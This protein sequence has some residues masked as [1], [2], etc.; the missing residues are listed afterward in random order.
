MFYSSFLLMKLRTALSST[1]LNNLPELRKVSSK[2]SWHCCS[3][4]IFLLLTFKFSIT[5]FRFLLFSSYTVSRKLHNTAKFVHT[6]FNYTST[7]PFFMLFFDL[8]SI[9]LF[10]YT[11]FSQDRYDFIPFFCFVLKQPNFNSIC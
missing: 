11:I 1:W 3:F 8:F 4:V 10:H 6:R 9:N 2:V 5:L 7:L